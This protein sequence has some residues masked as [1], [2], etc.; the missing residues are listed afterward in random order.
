MINNEIFYD[1]TVE[2]KAKIEI[3]KLAGIMIA[4]FMLMMLCSRL[5]TFTWVLVMLSN[6]SM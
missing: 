6:I 2:I 5:V 4:Q 3:I 1:Y